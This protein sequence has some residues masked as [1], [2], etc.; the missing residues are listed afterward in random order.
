M[1]QLQNFSEQLFYRTP[2]M[3]FFKST[4]KTIKIYPKWSSPRF[5]KN[6]CTKFF[7]FCEQFDWNMFFGKILF[8]CFWAKSAQIWLRTK[9]WKCYE[10]SVLPIFLTSGRNLQQ[11]KVLNEVGPKWN[12][13]F[14][15][16]LWIDF[17]WFVA[18][19]YNNIKA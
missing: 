4:E 8:W 16:N 9:F 2:G 10:K 6:L 14:I 11:Y 1:V 15:K 7:W 13:S 5:M 18:W 12:V 3:W 19:G 17:F